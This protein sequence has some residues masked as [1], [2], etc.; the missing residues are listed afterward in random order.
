MIAINLALIGKNYEKLSLINDLQ[1]EKDSVLLYDMP[2]GSR[3]WPLD[4][5]NDFA[6]RIFLESHKILEN[7]AFEV[8]YLCS[9]LNIKQRYYEWCK[10]TNLKKYFNL[11]CFPFSVRLDV[12]DYFH[13]S[14]INKLNEY[15]KKVNFIQ[16]M[17]SPALYRLK[18]IDRFYK[19]PKY[20]YSC[21]PQ[22]H[23]EISEM[24]FPRLPNGFDPVKNIKLLSDI[25]SSTKWIN[26]LHENDFKRYS[27]S[28]RINDIT[29]NKYVFNSFLPKECFES[30]CDVVLETYLQGPVYFTEKT[31]KEFFYKRPFISIGEKN[32]NNYL[33]DLGF[34][35]YD[36]IFDYA[37]DVES[38]IE[39]RLQKFW[40]QIENQLNNDIAHFDQKL[41]ILYDKLIYNRNT[42][43][44]WIKNIDKFM[45][46][47]NIYQYLY[48]SA[49]KNYKEV[50]TND[51]FETIK[52]ICLGFK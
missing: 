40:N 41:Q 13:E 31:W 9:D 48:L 18:T 43:L 24:S 45:E 36:D 46:Y 33:K 3:L 2:E 49:E 30:C 52:K 14:S 51:Q 34:L 29:Y 17:S 37:F 27:E 1:Y 6:W 10:K 23:G 42:Y 19:H 39:K 4:R 11:L 12:I 8:W 47:K 32:H 20:D 26:E 7:H 16:L 50:L 28:I 35:L 38:E 25:E 15:V 44:T 5:P 22:F 21:V